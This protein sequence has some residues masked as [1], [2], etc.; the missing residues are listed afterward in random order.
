MSERWQLPGFSGRSGLGPAVDGRTVGEAL[1]VLSV[2]LAVALAGGAVGAFSMKVQLALAAGLIG[3]LGL[4]LIPHRRTLLIALWVLVEPLS[5]EKILYT[6]PP[7]WEDLRGQELII[8]GGD[9]LLI[10]LACVL[11][12]T[13]GLRW[14]R[15]ASLFLLLAAW[16]LLSWLLHRYWLQDVY[17]HLAPLGLLH[18]LRNLALVVVVCSAIRTRADLL[19]VLLATMLILGLESVLVV[20][21]Y[22]DHTAYN[23]ARLLGQTIPLQT[24]T[25]GDATV[26]RATGTLGV[27][28]QQALFHVMFS[29]LLI[30]LLALRHALFRK[31]A[32][33]TLMA[34]LGAVILTFARTAWLS[35]GLAG[36]LVGYLFLRA[37]E[38]GPRA[39][40]TAAMLAL[41]MVG[42]LAVLIQPVIDRLTVGDDGATDSRV[43]MM[44]LAGD[45]FQRNP[46]IGAGPAEYPEA[47]LVLYPPGYQAPEWVPLG[48][49]PIVPPLGRI[50]LARARVTGQKD[51]IVPLSVHNKYLLTLSELGIVGL[52]I[53]L[54]IFAEFF[55]A[56]RVCARATDRLLRFTGLAGFGVL[57]I[58]LLYQGLDQFVDDKTLQILLFPLLVIYAAANLARE[59][60]QG[61]ASA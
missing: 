7:L 47:G 20:L 46:I 29:L 57:L 12:R 44:V 28:N 8:N 17:I 33:L 27:P 11:L 42:A 61:R 51:V 6:G 60:T 18:M 49:K 35:S 13:T 4:L 50:E 10:M 32:L 24:Y 59:E 15:L 30:G 39:R 26:V 45:L 31:L 2:S 19:W 14:S 25:G 16:G 54:A 21:S 41:V 53:W 22:R 40:L 38:L 37:G 3:V 58:A 43:R 23:F 1:L 52:L 9:V 56:I 36:M 55:R 48:S 34:S 5:I